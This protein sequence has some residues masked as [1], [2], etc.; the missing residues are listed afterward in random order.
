MVNKQQDK[1]ESV[2]IATEESAPHTTMEEWMDRH[3]CPIFF[4]FDVRFFLALLRLV[5]F[6]IEPDALA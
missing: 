2:A 6:A 5:I 4:N 3:A 1:V